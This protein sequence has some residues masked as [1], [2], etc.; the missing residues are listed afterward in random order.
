MT[1]RGCLDHKIITITN[2]RQE[3]EYLLVFSVESNI[4]PSSLSY[5]TITL[6]IRLLIFKLSL[7]NR[8]RKFIQAASKN[9]PKCPKLVVKNLLADTFNESTKFSLVMELEHIEK[10][11]LRIDKSEKPQMT[12]LVLNQI[13]EIENWKNLHQTKRKKFLNK[14][15]DIFVEK[16]FNFC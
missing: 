3:K 8:L 10:L 2:Y 15:K 7:E 12:I 16:R 1:K 13:P 9:F 14:Q 6:E 4:S 11:V 5:L